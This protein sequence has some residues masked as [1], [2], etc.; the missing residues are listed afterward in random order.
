MIL[1][2]GNKEYVKG[3]RNFRLGQVRTRRIFF[4]YGLTLSNKSDNDLNIL[5]PYALGN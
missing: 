4:R 5:Y 2:F 3:L 1:N